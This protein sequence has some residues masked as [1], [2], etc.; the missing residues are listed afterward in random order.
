MFLWLLW[1][2]VIS[3]LTEEHAVCVPNWRLVLLGNGRL[4]LDSFVIE[5]F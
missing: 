4:N 1:S 2:S 3:S 5:H